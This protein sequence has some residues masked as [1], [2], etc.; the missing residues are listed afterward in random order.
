LGELSRQVF[1]DNLTDWPGDHLMD[2]TTVPG[3][4]LTNRPLKRPAPNL[5][6]LAGALLAEFGIEGFPAR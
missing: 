5:Q 1:E 3:I 4:L 2:H 6:S